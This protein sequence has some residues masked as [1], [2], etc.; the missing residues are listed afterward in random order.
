MKFLLPLIVVVALSA[1]AATF[2]GP[3][4]STTSQ[5]NQDRSQNGGPMGAS[6]GGP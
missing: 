3:G 1:C 5:P 2:P 4:T 6:T